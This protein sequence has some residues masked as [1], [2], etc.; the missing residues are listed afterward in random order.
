MPK[1]TLKKRMS[2]GLQCAHSQVGGARKTRDQLSKMMER[3][4]L[5]ACLLATCSVHCSLAA[6]GPV[7]A[8][9]YGEVNTA[10]LYL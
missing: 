5:L 1:A 8:T 10:A 2:S 3:P 4:L 7:V 9:L 6:D